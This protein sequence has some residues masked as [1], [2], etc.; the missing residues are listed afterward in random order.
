MDEQ[1]HTSCFTEEDKRRLFTTIGY[2]KKGVEDNTLEIKKQ[3]GNVADMRK[4][5]TRH[6][7]F[8]GKI[9]AITALMA[10]FASVVFTAAI[11]AWFRIWQ[12]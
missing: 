2:I 12:N 4:I 10:F 1:K 9:G 3:N 8:L 5:V 6:E 11:N 7:V